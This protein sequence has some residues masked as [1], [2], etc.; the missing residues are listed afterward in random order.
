M[1]TLAP[2]R[3]PLAARRAGYTVAAVIDAALLYAVNVR[4]GWQVV[5][6]LTAGTVQVVWLVNLSMIVG[7]AANLIYV[8][9]DPRWLRSAGD[10][11]GAVVGTAVLIKTLRVF[12]FAFGESAVN[13]ELVARTVLIVAIVL[14]AVAAVAHLVSLLRQ[15]SGR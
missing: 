6:F 5:P 13:W 2:A 1:N 11:A 8:I 14:T 12:P 3:R 15:A 4:P 7:L 9:H 10:L